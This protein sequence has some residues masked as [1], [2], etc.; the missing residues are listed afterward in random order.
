M[1]KFIVFFLFLLFVFTSNAQHSQLIEVD[2]QFNEELFVKNLVTGETA[3]RIGFDDAIFNDESPYTPIYS[4]RFQVSNLGRLK[5]EI[6]NL[7][8]LNES[9]IISI[10]KAEYIKNVETALTN[11]LQFDSRIEQN[12]IKYFSEVFFTPI[13][14]RLSY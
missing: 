10:N 1:R 6:V 3:E 5:I 11:S 8:F 4:N 7:S 12:K 9:P 13:I 14:N 2:F